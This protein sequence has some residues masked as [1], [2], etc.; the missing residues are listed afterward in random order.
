MVINYINHQI[1]QP[2]TL[3][4]PTIENVNIS[5]DVFLSQCPYRKY[6]YGKFAKKSVILGIV[7]YETLVLEQGKTIT[8]LYFLINYNIFYFSLL[9]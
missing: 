1:L 9:R 6:K 8:F 3:F 5:V 7:E 4:K 2:D